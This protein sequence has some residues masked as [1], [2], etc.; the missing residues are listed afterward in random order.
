[1]P[2]GIYRT[3]LAVV[4]LD[5]ITYNLR[6][7]RSLLPSSVA[8]C[9]IVKANAYGHGA[10]PVSRELEAHDV[11]AFGVATIEEGLELRQ[12]GI[13]RPILVL[14]VGFSG[15]E[16]A[17][18]HRLAPVIYSPGMA[19]RVS[20]AARRMKKPLSVHLKIDTGM[21]RLGLLGDEWKGVL[22]DLLEKLAL[23]LERHGGSAQCA[24]SEEIRNLMKKK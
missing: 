3:T 12:A 19:E 11:E 24:L 10:V 14:G 6:A 18:E 2:T 9:A 7:L 22:E 5:A 23:A 15:I 4:D 21:G 1:M 16:A 13:E 20:R 17:Q 8:I